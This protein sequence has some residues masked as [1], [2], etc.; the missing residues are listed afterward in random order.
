MK[1]VQLFVLTN[2]WGSRLTNSCT[3]HVANY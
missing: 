3:R 2:L 1:F